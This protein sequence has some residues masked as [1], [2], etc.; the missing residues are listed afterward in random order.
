M[1]DPTL[2]DLIERIDKLE[3]GKPMLSVPLVLTPR[4]VDANKEQRIAV[5]PVCRFQCPGN[6]REPR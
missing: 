6:K 3:R 5:R 2:K 4:L 1:A